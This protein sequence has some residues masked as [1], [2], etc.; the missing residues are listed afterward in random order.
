M[1][2][3]L[4]FIHNSSLTRI[5]LFFNIAYA[6]KRMGCDVYLLVFKNS[7]NHRIASSA[8]FKT[9][10]NLKNE[11]FDKALLENNKGRIQELISPGHRCKDIIYSEIGYLPYTMQLDRKGVNSDA[12]YNV[13]NNALYKIERFRNWRSYLKYVEITPYRVSIKK[14]LPWVISHPAYLGDIAEFLYL[15]CMRLYYPEKKRTL[16]D[17]F[18]F[19]PFQLHN[20]TQILHNS[21]YIHSMHDI[22]E[23]FHDDIRK[24]FPC[25]GI[26][27]KEHP[28]DFGLLAYRGLRR[29]YSDVI[30]LRNYNF[31]TLIEKCS[32]MITVNSSS[33]FKALCR[34]K[35]VL[36]LGNCFYNKNGFVEHV[37]RPP[38]FT[39]KLSALLKKEVDKS[40]VDRY[41]RHFREYIFVDGN[42][43]SDGGIANLKPKTIA[44]IL[45][46]MFEAE[47]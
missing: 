47:R 16:P 22:L 2:V 40:G 12:S 13:D 32:A 19:I 20:D 36:T 3:A 1:K 27:V 6:L 7:L 21:P 5:S 23:L 31:N 33:G 26:V 8:G 14:I 25:Y 45:C 38:L 42:I 4:E 9:V 30:W 34:Y 11:E 43:S 41:M 46:Y 44:E 39:E 18:F 37:S 24:N 29:K 15:K 28:Y 10:Y 35:K 17:K